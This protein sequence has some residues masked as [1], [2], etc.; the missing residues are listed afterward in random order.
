MQAHI[1]DEHVSFLRG[2]PLLLSV[3]G[4]IFVHAGLRPGIA[5]LD[6]GEEDMLWIRDEFLEAAHDFGAVVVHGH[7]PVHQPFLS[8]H[9]IGIDTGCFMTGRLTALRIDAAGETR[10]LQTGPGAEF[11]R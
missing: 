2:L 6:Q 8:S 1:P 9:R 5:L 4:Y 11:G 3:P 10:L 7:T